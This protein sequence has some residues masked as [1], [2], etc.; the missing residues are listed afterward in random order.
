MSRE[1][2]YALRRF[3]EKLANSSTMGGPMTTTD[4]MPS[5]GSPGFAPRK[6]QMSDP[7]DSKP[8]ASFNQFPG[9]PVG[10][11]PYKSP[12]YTEDVLPAPK[13]LDNPLIAGT[14]ASD[15]V[16]ATANANGGVQR[17]WGDYLGQL[18]GNIDWSMLGGAG[19]GGL[20]AYGLARLLQ[21]REDE[22]RGRFPWLATLLGA[23]AGGLLAPHI[24]GNPYVQSAAAGAKDMAASGYNAVMG[25]G[26][27]T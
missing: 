16:H 8:D 19:I 7:R 15:K 1:T 4:L 20:G 6:S 9:L 24:M 26:Q 23:G 2:V 14:P 3:T 25:S 13:I 17:D 10:L 21:S 11:V 27:K 5:D 12:T 18:A 22:E